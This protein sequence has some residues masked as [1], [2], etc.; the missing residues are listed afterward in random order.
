MFKLSESP[1]WSEKTL[2]WYWVDIIECKVFRLFN[3]SQTVVLN[4]EGPV[5]NLINASDGFVVSLENSIVS[6][7]QGFEAKSV[8]SEIAHD[9]NFRCNDGAVGPDGTFYFGTMEK[10]PQG[11]DGKLYS[12]DIRGNLLEQGSGIGIPNSFI[13]LDD[14]LVLISDSF[15]QKTFK[16]ELLVDGNLNWSGRELW[17]DLSHT[18]AT[19]DGGTLDE[20]GNIWLAIWGGAV[21][22]QYSPDGVLLDKIELNALQPTS[23][24]F[25]GS[26]MN[27]LLITTATEGMNDDQLK[28]YPESGRVIQKSMAV[29]GNISPIFAVNI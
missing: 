28:L 2:S 11:L 9:S 4:I 16:V 3:G 23:C 22:H 1:V 26:N 29:K 18:S 20:N 6:Y 13:W 12:L 10:K 19:P 25:G 27:E 17:L 24:A 8:L 5:S 21:V 7:S 15:L 14:H